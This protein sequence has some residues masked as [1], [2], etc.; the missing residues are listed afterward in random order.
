MVVGGPRGDGDHRTRQ[1]RL[2]QLSRSDMS[3]GMKGMI[4]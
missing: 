1:S 4:A 3:G 2:G